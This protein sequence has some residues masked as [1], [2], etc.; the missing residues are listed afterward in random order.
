MISNR[1]LSEKNYYTSTNTFVHEYVYPH[2]R[3]EERTAKG[4]DPDVD[5]VTNENRNRS[6]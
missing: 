3:V 5:L 4:L 2:D 6:L 1:Q